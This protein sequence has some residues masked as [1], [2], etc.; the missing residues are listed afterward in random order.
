VSWPSGARLGFDGTPFVVAGRQ[1]LECSA[2]QPWSAKSKD[3]AP[4]VCIQVANYMTLLFTV[5]LWSWSIH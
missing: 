4:R 2:G 1:V 3:T 5:F